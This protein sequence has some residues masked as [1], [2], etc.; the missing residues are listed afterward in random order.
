MITV[1]KGTN[2]YLAEPGSLPSGAVPELLTLAPGYAPIAH[3]SVILGHDGDSVT[4][5]T[6]ASLGKTE[7]NKLV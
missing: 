5:F 1:A 3:F 2:S 7:Y 6:H 4:V